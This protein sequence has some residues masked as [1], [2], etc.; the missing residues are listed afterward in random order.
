VANPYFVGAG[1]AAY[2]ATTAFPASIAVSDSTPAN[3][4]TGDR[5]LLFVTMFA[6]ATAT[7]TCPTPSGW[8]LVGSQDLSNSVMGYVA[9]YVFTARWTSAATGATVSPTITTS[10]SAYSWRLQAA[11]WRPS[12]DVGATAV[13]S[14]GRFTDNNN[15]FFGA[16]SSRYGTNG[17]MEIAAQVTQTGTLT[18]TG[19]VSSAPLTLKLDQA[20][21]TNRGGA[22]RVADL[23]VTSNISTGSPDAWDR[24]GTTN[25][26][27]QSIC[28]HGFL[29]APSDDPALGTGWSVGR[30]K[31]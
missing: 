3:V 24:T 1:P 27:T 21:I 11:A 2:D 31:Y 28:W 17:S 30:I 20:A 4:V 5:V 14:G 8:T 9:M 15:L 25:F 12:K 18:G 26:Y 16:I 23:L 6:N 19:P 10:A 22:F 13:S 7:S 29:D